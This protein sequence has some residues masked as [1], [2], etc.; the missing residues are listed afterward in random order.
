MNIKEVIEAEDIKALA[1]QRM[2]KYYLDF[3]S[4]VANDYD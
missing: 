4:K 1:K 3:S 2:L